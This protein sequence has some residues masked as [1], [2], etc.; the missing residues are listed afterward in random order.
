M[1]SRSKVAAE[2]SGLFLESV[3]LVLGLGFQHLEGI[4]LEDALLAFQL[5]ELPGHLGVPLERTR[6]PRFSPDSES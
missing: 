3:S 2:A 1:R 6:P 5:L 4:E